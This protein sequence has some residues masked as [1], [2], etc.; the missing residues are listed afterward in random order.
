MNYLVG[1]GFRTGRI[2]HPC[3]SYIRGLLS[4]ERKKRKA[5][6]KWNL[7]MIPKNR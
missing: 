5:S 3:I 2:K 4:K 7:K 6:G 1:S